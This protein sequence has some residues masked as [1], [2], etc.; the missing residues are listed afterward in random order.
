MVVPVEISRHAGVAGQQID[1]CSVVPQVVAVLRVG[2]KVT[3]EHDPFLRFGCVPQLAFNPFQLIVSHSAFQLG[4]RGLRDLWYSEAALVLGSSLGQAYRLHVVAVDYD[5]PPTF[6]GEIVVTVFQPELC[7]HQ[8]LFVIRD[9][10][11]VVAQHVIVRSLQPVVDRHHFVETFKVPVNEVSE[12]HYEG[13]IQLVV[14]L[15]AGG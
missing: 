14:M 9:L 11:V 2:G 13:K 12:M 5:E 3:K 1:Q 15:H 10:E 8:C 6:T 7:R 4:G